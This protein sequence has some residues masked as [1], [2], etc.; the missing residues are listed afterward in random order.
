MSGA[1]DCLSGASVFGVMPVMPLAFTSPVALDERARVAVSE[2]DTQ[3]EDELEVDEH[4][5]EI[6]PE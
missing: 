5:D 6:E 4:D 2:D 1:F 3:E